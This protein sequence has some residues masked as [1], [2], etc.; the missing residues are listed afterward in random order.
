MSAGRDMCRGIAGGSRFGGKLLG[1]MF[2]L[3]GSAGKFGVLDSVLREIF[4]KNNCG[5]EL[6]SIK[7]LI[8]VK[9][10]DNWWYFEWY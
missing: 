3:E 1:N 8:F 4:G 9:L 6:I 2:G 7:R 10:I 5:G